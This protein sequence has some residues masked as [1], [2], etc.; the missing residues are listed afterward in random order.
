MHVDKRTL[1]LSS[2]TD[3]EQLKSS[4]FSIGLNR[5]YFLMRK[6]SIADPSAVVVASIKNSLRKLVE[7]D[8]SRR[9]DL[10]DGDELAKN[11]TEIA[12]KEKRIGAQ[13]FVD[14]TP[15]PSIAIL[16]AAQLSQILDFAMVYTPTG[17]E[18]T[19][20]VQFRM[21]QHPLV[22]EQEAILTS[23]CARSEPFTL[24]RLSEPLGLSEASGIRKLSRWVNDLVEMDLISKSETTRNITYT[25][26]STGEGLAKGLIA[27]KE[28]SPSAIHSHLV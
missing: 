7:I 19:R 28:I 22:N 21:G 25:L 10:Y 4:I 2:G 8:D 15:A 17:D 3:E 13:V 12:L 27:S 16:R 14:L 26:T 9:V 18:R 5:V 23:L 24:R 6:D 11:L 1:I 20:P